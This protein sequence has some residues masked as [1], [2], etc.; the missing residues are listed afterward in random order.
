[1]TGLIGEAREGE[2]TITGDC[3]GKTHLPADPK[4]ILD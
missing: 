3:K 1:V 2:Q 4:I